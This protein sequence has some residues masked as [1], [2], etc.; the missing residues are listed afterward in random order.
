MVELRYT[1]LAEGTS[2]KALMPILNWLL[3][4]CGVRIAIQ[5]QWADLVRLLHPPKDLSG[6]IQKSLEDYPCDLLFIHRDADNS[7]PQ[8]RLMEIQEAVYNIPNSRFEH[9]CVIPVRMTE[10]W[11]L[12]DEMAIRHAAGNPN[13]NR[14]LDMP[15]LNGLEQMADPKR[16]LERLLETASDL[17]GRRLKDFRSQPKAERLERLAE[18]IRDFTPLRQLPAF[19]ALEGDL[20]NVLR[21]MELI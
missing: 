4:Q 9:V 14:R 12:I 6:K 13:G 16:Q 11:L 21:R 2:D 10:A 18:R 20:R 15:T 1:L 7:S 3:E 8:G 17:N 5:S 19:N